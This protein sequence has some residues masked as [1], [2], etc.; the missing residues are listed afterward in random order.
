MLLFGGWEIIT[1]L[2]ILKYERPERARI[3]YS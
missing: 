2:C 1:Y 3:Y